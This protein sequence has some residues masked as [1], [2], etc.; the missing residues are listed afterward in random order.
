[1]PSIVWEILML[2]KVLCTAAHILCTKILGW[3]FAGERP[4]ERKVM[5]LGAPH[6]S[7]LDYFLTLALIHHFQ[8]PLKYLVKNNLFKGPMAPL[9]RSLGG[10]PVDRSKSNKLVVA[11]VASVKA[12]DEIAIGVLPE[13]TRRYV[14]YWKSGF[15]FIAKGAELP[16]YPVLVD[17]AAK[18]V[19][20]GPRLVP[21]GDL[22]GDVAKLAEFFGDTKG[23]K[24]ENSGP[25]RVRPRKDREARL[26]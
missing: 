23:V 19:A 1:M 7:N 4:S 5:L 22:E 11:I 21:S 15:Y 16:I 13:G 17:G 20:V 18:C 24:P 6:T 25:V 12:E 14:D 8:L 26:A 9:L 10:I 2:I 3:T